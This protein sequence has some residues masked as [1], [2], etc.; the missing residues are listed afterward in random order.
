MCNKISLG[1]TSINSQIVINNKNIINQEKK[2]TKNTDIEINK[3]SIYNGKR[4]DSSTN[5][6]ST[7]SFNKDKN[8]VNLQKKNLSEKIDKN[9]FNDK[10]KLENNFNKQLKTLAS[11]ILSTNSNGLKNIVGNTFVKEIR[12]ILNKN[13]NVPLSS[14]DLIKLKKFSQQL[15]SN[16][17]NFTTRANVL[18]SMELFDETINNLEKIKNGEFS[19]ENKFLNEIDNVN[20]C[21]SSID[22]ALNS[23]PDA[24][25]TPFTSTINKVMREYKKAI[26]SGDPKRIALYSAFIEKFLKGIN[27]GGGDKLAQ[28]ISDF[29]N[30]KNIPFNKN[31]SASDQREAIKEYLGEQKYSILFNNDNRQPE[32]NSHTEIEQDNKVS[33]SDN[34]DNP[35]K[36]MEDLRRSWGDKDEE[37]NI[38]PPKPIITREELTEL[39]RV[40]REEI[41]S[42]LNSFPELRNALEKLEKVNHALILIENA[43]GN[44]IN[45]NT[46][47]TEV[48]NDESIENK[49]KQIINE[50]IEKVIEMEG[51]L[52]LSIESSDNEIVNLL[53]KFREIINKLDIDTRNNIRKNLEATMISQNHNNYMRD[54]EIR[55]KN[56]DKV[57]QEINNLFDELKEKRQQIN[58]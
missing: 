8:I 3:N 4:I 17:D 49:A 9:D 11:T 26:N 13:D 52:D 18:D 15:I 53:K 1:S 10:S 56:V 14:D 40:T 48:K 24:Q 37:G 57:K 58:L 25:R 29:E 54:M 50:I 30:V 16:K 12:D 34:I 38:I 47:S 23:I 21:L 36:E 45:T 31:M 51:N 43:I 2:E 41:Q 46:H 19:L 39:S 55:W 44:F 28:I 5:D 7:L 6:P 35:D 20:N 27:E 32:S 22:L 42:T 33:N